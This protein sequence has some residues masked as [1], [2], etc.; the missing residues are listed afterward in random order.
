MQSRQYWIE[1]FK[2]G[3]KIGCL[4][5]YGVVAYNIHPELVNER[6]QLFI[7]P[8][9]DYALNK[10]RESNIGDREL[11]YRYWLMG[12]KLQYKRENE[13]FDLIDAEHVTEKFEVFH[14]ICEDRRFSLDTEDVLVE[15][16]YNHCT[17]QVEKHIAGTADASKAC[18]EKLYKEDGLPFV[19]SR[20]AKL[21]GEVLCL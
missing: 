16:V 10:V 1:A 2:E 13:V 5:E 17:E 7:D 8:L 19:V 15:L 4:D 11:E 18:L 21:S 3:A 9:C 14:G 20:S 12:G 6:L